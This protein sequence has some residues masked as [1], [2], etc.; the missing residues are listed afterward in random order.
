M[1]LIAPSKVSSISKNA[2]QA[3]TTHSTFRFVSLKTQ[4]KNKNLKKG[5]I[6]YDSQR[7]SRKCVRALQKHRART[8]MAFRTLCVCVGRGNTPFVREARTNSNV[9]PELH[10]CEPPRHSRTCY[11]KH[12]L[13]RLTVVVSTLTQRKRGVK[14]K[15]W[16]APRLLAWVLT[17]VEHV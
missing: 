15:G 11:G 13:K 7:A 17:M 10:F 14:D 16:A 1:Q 12:M 3:V 9:T 5:K 6:T 2:S 4:E 8:R